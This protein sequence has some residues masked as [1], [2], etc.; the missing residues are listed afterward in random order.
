[1]VMHGRTSYQEMHRTAARRC[2]FVSAGL[3]G[4]WIRSQRPFSAPDGDP[5]RSL[6]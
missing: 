4:R 6:Q 1:M 5:E 3:F 2:S